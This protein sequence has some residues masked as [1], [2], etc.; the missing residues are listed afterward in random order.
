MWLSVMLRWEGERHEI[1]EEIRD[2]KKRAEMDAGGSFSK[3]ECISISSDDLL[4]FLSEKVSM[5]GITPRPGNFFVKN[6]RCAAFAQKQ[7]TVNISSTKNALLWQ[8]LTALELPTP[9]AL[10]NESTV[11]LLHVGFHKL[12]PQ[13]QHFTLR[14]QLLQW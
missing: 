11:L 13:S 10:Q 8:L 14:R 7:E 4:T 12:V 1:K 9:H 2:G 6:V 5:Q 3:A